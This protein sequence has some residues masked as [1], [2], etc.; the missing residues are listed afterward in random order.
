[1]REKTSISG[2][3][4][5]ILLAFLV[6]GISVVFGEPRGLLFLF[7]NIV[8]VLVIIFYIILARTEFNETY[9]LKH[10]KL[11]RF[12]EIL[13]VILLTFFFFIQ[14]YVNINGKTRTELNIFYLL[15]LLILWFT[16]Y[17]TI[18]KWGNE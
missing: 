18:R 8:I 2:Y 9:S 15:S 14:L 6:L 16:A 5:K 1:M 4:I 3:I 12:E 13:P 10:N 11:K 7:T 17:R